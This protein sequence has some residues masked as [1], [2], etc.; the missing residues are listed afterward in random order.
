[1]NLV[2]LMTEL[3]DAAGSIAGLR[4][5]A[6]PADNIAPP[7]ALV[8]LPDDIT[9]D[10]AYQRGADSMSIEVDVL[11]ARVDDRASAKALAEYLAG[12][13][14]KSVKAALEAGTY[15]G[16]TI[17]VSKATTGAFRVADVP[18]AGATFTVD[19]LGSGS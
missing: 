6:F 15:T 16:A 2:T 12:S 1:V 11:V 10:L 13:G 5:Y 9:W 7:A 3:A 14:A 17:H 4:S 8:V 18:Y 19:V